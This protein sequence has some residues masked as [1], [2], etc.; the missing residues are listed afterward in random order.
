MK[1]KSTRQFLALVT[2]ITAFAAGNAF[3]TQY[4]WL[5]TTNTDW[6]TSSNWN[7]NGV[8]QTNGTFVHRLSVSN[9]PTNSSKPATYNFPGVTTTYLGDS[10]SGGRGLVIGSAGANAG[11][12]STMLISGGTFSTLG[13]LGAD[14]IGNGNTNAGTLTIDGTANSGDA[15][16]IG[17]DKGISFGLGFGSFATLNIKN[18]SATLFDLTTNN[19]T[20]TINLETGGTLTMNRLA[21]AG[22]G[23]NIININGGTLKSRTASAT[24][25]ATPTN[26]N[27]I[28]NVKAAGAIIDSGHNITI[29]RPLLEDATSLGGGIT[30]NGTATLTLGGVST[31]TGPAVINAGGLIIPAGVASWPPSSFSHSGSILGFNIGVYNPA[32]LAPISTGN[33]SFNA[34]I[35]V[36]VSGSQFVVGQ[37]PLINYSGTIT[38]FENLTLNTASL[39]P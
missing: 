23:N 27:T 39:P 29:A 14:I 7:V 19:T 33:L 20:A 15:Q 3:A 12:N 37:I 31:T 25:I 35:S 5:G 16:F 30:K 32:N 36:N 2:S 21:Y 34:P 10:A 13:G 38:G 24:F 26:G 1:P 18:G 6:A 17:I 28:I 4:T 8:A 9:T 11:V 22:G